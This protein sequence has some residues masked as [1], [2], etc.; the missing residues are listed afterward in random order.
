MDKNKQNKT[1]LGISSYC[2]P[3][4]VGVPG[5]MPPR[6]MTAEE[7]VNKATELKVS[8][9]QIADN[10]PL[11]RLT[12]IQLDGL[13][14]YAQRN[15]ISLE[16]GTR[17]IQPENIGRYIEIAKRLN[18]NLLR[19]VIDS[20]GYEPD[21]GEIHAVL[22]G[23]LP[24]LRKENI[25]LGIENHDR[26]KSN[27]FKKIVKNLNDSYI[28]IVLDTVNSFSCEENTEAVLKNLAQYTVNFHIKDFS[29]K[30]IQNQ[31]GLIVTGTP[32]GEGLLKLPRVLETLKIKAQSD[33]SS[34][35]EFWMNPE[36]TIE[37]T[38]EKESY[39]VEKSINFLRT[40]IPD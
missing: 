36:P 29:I 4:A 24:K 10:L 25:V 15:G 33:F 5:F 11:D 35:L 31:M 7:L 9:V 28:G 37:K 3:F 39:W 34:I 17:G 30:R 16:V 6:P 26:F 18:S 8:V 27:I 14:S 13:A 23:I 12:D 32:A 38:L 1:R 19:C 21:L 2:Y 40:L 22:S 20:A